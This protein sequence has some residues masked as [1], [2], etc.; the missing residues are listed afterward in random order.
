MHVGVFYT[1]TVSAAAQLLAEVHMHEFGIY[2]RQSDLE[3][4]QLERIT[5]LECSKLTEVLNAQAGIDTLILG[6]RRLFPRF[7]EG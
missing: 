4:W 3:V 5:S 1:R 2:T 7:L 6:P